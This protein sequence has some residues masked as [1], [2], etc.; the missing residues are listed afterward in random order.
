MNY[1]VANFGKASDVLDVN[2]S[3]AAAEKETGITF[4]WKDTAPFVPTE[5]NTK[6]PLDVDIQASLSNMRDM[7]GIHGAW[8]AIQLDMEMQ[9][10]PITSS[11]GL[12]QYTHPAPLVTNL[13]PA[14]MDYPVPSFGADPD[15]TTTMNSIKVAEEQVKHK[16]V[17]GTA[18]SKA[19]WHNVAKDTLYDFNMKLDADV[20]TTNRNIA[21]AEDDIGVT[22]VPDN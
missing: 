3:I 15:M 14:V 20:I 21:K 11:I 2:Q 22:M 17:M 5:Y 7:E 13:Q 6:R 8:D 9:S 18:D 16:L 10:D 4:K 12:T 1:P 19:K